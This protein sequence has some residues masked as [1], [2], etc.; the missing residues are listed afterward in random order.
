MYTGPP[1]RSAEFVA[2]QVRRL[3]EGILALA[4][5]AEAAVAAG[6]EDANR[7][8][9]WCRSGDH[10]GAGGALQL[11]AGNGGLHAEFLMGHPGG[12]DWMAPVFRSCRFTPSCTESMA[13]SRRP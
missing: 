5:D 11:G 4:G 9:R 2:H 7:G 10:D 12:R 6:F 8:T 3:G 1:Q 13:E